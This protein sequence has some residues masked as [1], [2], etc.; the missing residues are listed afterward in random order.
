VD[1][2]LLVEDLE[3]MNVLQ[4]KYLGVAHMFFSA[5]E[6]LF[7][8][9]QEWLEQ[10]LLLNEKQEPQKRSLFYPKKKPKPL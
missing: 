4:M 8:L 2:H 9:E 7:L 5:D 1:N 3:K 10:L 6:L